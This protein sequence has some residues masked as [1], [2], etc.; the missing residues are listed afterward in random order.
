M[1]GTTVQKMKSFL[2]L[3]D[4]IENSGQNSLFSSATYVPAKY[5]HSKNAFKTVL[6]RS[7]AEINSFLVFSF[8]RPMAMQCV[9][10]T[11]TLVTV[12]RK[13]SN[14]RVISV[15]LR[16]FRVISGNSVKV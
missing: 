1:S 8:D 9:P 5:I 12:K 13:Y 10:L 2:L 14:Y 6:G 15:N 11:L 4:I 16:N 7:E 3:S